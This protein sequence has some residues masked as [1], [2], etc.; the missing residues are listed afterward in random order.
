[1][2]T[3]PKTFGH[4]A[5]KQARARERRPSASKRGYDRRW[6][7]YSRQFLARNPHCV[8]VLIKGVRVHAAS[9]QG[10]SECTDHIEAVDGADDP[11]FYDERNHQPLSVACN[12]LKRRRVDHAGKSDTN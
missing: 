12:S 9:C 3:A 5:R 4:E 8:G 11:L 10:R 7:D 2:P 6:Q 1:M